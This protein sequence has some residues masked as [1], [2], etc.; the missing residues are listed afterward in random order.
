MEKAEKKTKRVKKAYVKPETKKHKAVSI[1]SGSHS[2]CD[3][4]HSRSYYYTYYH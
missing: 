2:D 1:I 3:Y 4:Y